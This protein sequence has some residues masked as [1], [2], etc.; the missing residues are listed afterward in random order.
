M[1]NINAKFNKFNKL[2]IGLIA[3]ITGPVF[4]FIVFYLIAAADRSFMGFVKMIINNSST[5]SGII[6]ICLIFNL[7]FFYIALR[8]DFY[9]SAQGVIMATFLYAPFV[10]YFKYVA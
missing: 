9:K 2:W 10:V 5:H 8:K 4:G 6:S 1:D 7:V 3:G